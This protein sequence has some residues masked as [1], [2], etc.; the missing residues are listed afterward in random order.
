[1][2]HL[3]KSIPEDGSILPGQDIDSLAQTAEDSIAMIESATKKAPLHDN[4]D[5]NAV[6]NSGHYAQVYSLQKQKAITA[7]HSRLAGSNEIQMNF[8][9][10]RKKEG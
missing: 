2:H 10:D 6:V 1:M 7:A 4:S 8:S 3:H 9:S 5:I